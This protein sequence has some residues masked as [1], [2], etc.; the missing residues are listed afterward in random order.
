VR[1]LLHPCHL[2]L[3]SALYCLSVSVANAQQLDDLRE[4]VENDVNLLEFGATA[5]GQTT[6]RE[7]NSSGSYELDLIGSYKVLEHDPGQTVGDGRV[8][9]WVFSVGGV[10]GSFAFQHDYADQA[11]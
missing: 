1:S 11:S 5:I 9:F 10:S 7:G 3:F 6:V 2:I 4:A 8:D